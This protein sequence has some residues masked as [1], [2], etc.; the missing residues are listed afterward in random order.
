[1]GTRENDADEA[2]YEAQA[3]YGYGARLLAGEWVHENDIPDAEDV[4]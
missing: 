4:L 1:M 3:S 2:R